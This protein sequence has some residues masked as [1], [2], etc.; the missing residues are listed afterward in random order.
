MVPVL[1]TQR[2]KV[3]VQYFFLLSLEILD[4]DSVSLKMVYLLQ[5]DIETVTKMKM[6]QRSYFIQYTKIST[7]LTIC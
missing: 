5:T 4:T 2:K 6:Q 1:Q 3:Q 7:E